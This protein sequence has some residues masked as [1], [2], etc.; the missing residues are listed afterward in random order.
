MTALKPV[1]YEFHV[2]AS[3]RAD[4][5]ACAQESP[6]DYTFTG[7]SPMLWRDGVAGSLLQKSAQITRCVVTAYV[8]KV[9]SS[10]VL[11]FLGYH[12]GRQPNLKKW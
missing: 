5:W 4:K 1:S 8:L 12:P 9:E 3:V 7:L 10:P 11:S 2:G 6:D